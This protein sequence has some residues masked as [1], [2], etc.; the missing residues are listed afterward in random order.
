MSRLSNLQPAF[1]AIV[2]RAVIPVDRCG[3]DAKDREKP[4]R[5]ARP[6]DDS[7]CALYLAN[8]TRAACMGI[9]DDPC[10]MRRKG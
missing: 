8:L 6:I 3:D 9:L 2:G 7:L 10:A 1:D 5:A 4:A